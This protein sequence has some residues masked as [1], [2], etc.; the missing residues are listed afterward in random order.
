MPDWVGETGVSF[1]V[2]DFSSTLD[3]KKMDQNLL[4]EK[5]C[6]KNGYG[7]TGGLSHCGYKYEIIFII[8][9]TITVVIFI[10]AYVCSKFFCW[11]EV[12]FGE[13]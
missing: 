12:Y 1:F 6:K 4:E 5:M 3:L 9:M 8:F 10:L 2:V 11:V 7:D 13:N